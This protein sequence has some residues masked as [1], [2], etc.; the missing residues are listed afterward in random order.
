MLADHHRQSGNEGGCCR[1][2]R[3]DPES[4]YS[5]WGCVMGVKFRVRFSCQVHSVKG[6]E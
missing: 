2:E 5:M 1:H 6:G 3:E 4:H